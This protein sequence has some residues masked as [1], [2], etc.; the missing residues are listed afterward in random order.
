MSEALSGL[1]CYAYAVLRRYCFDENI[2]PVPL[3]PP[4]M[5]NNMIEMIKLVLN[6]C[7]LL[8]SK[9]IYEVLFNNEFQL[10]DEFKLKIE[11]EHNGVDL[12]LASMVFKSKFLSLAVRS[13]V[14]RFYHKLIYFEPEEA[15]IK[16]KTA[17]C[18]LCDEPFINRNHIYFNCPKLFGIGRDFLRIL[19][20]LDPDYT[21]EE[22][23]YLSMIDPSL[24]QAT[25]LIANTI[26][27]ISSNREGCD[28]T[29][30]R[31]FLSSELEILQYSR[32]VDPETLCSFKILV[33]LLGN[34][35]EIVND[36]N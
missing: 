18:K 13:Q 1:N 29:R 20:V 15:K 26:F 35:D 27:F 25:W 12:Q 23:L 32:H 6:S 8:S 22:V 17:F 21:E 16:N 36:L 33:D 5:T 34:M 19:R 9:Q 31:A 14:F 10:S 2:L 4:F 11:L 7:D 24:P 3:K 30:Y 28:A